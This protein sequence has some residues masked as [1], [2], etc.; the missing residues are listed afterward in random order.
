[1]QAALV[2]IFVLG[3]VP[4]AQVEKANPPGPSKV[5]VE[6]HRGA[7]VYTPVVYPPTAR[8]SYPHAALN[9]TLGSIWP[10]PNFKYSSRFG[11]RPEKRWNPHRPDGYYYPRA[12]NYRVELDYPWHSS[13]R[14]YSR[15]VPPNS[16][17]RGGVPVTAPIKGSTGYGSGEPSPSPVA[18]PL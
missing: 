10:L 4:P 8:T 7:S 11:F 1:M 3:A 13:P 9:S 5:T 16:T 14:S 18:H 6:Q 2:L 15:R 12:F 17:P